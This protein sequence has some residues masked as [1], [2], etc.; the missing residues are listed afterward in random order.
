MSDTRFKQPRSDKFVD[1]DGW[2]LNDTSGKEFKED[3]SNQLQYIDQ[4]H[5]NY[6]IILLKN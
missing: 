2:I 6:K 4:I 5:C 3:H 1:I